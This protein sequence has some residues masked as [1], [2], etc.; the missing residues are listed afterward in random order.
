[1][2][3]VPSERLPSISVK[4]VISFLPSFQLQRPNRP[5]LVDHRLLEIQ[6]IAVLAPSPPGLN[7]RAGRVQ[8]RIERDQ[9]QRLA[10]AAGKIGVD[11]R[12]M[13]SLP[14]W[15]NSA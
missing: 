5:I 3:D 12:P 2:I 11:P 9:I 13:R 7:D 8:A 15:E 14:A 10:V 1:L 4:A 6:I